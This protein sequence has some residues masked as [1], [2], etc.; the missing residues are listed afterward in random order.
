MADTYETHPDEVI[1]ALLGLIKLYAADGLSQR[2]ILNRVAWTLRE[3]GWGLRGESDCHLV[4]IIT[5]QA[6]QVAV[7][8]GQLAL[9][10]AGEFDA[11]SFV[12]PVEPEIV[13]L[14]EQQPPAPTHAAQAAPA[15]PPTP[16]QFLKT[17]PNADPLPP[18]EQLAALDR[19]LDHVIALFEG[20]MTILD[21]LHGRQDR[22]YRGEMRVMGRKTTVTL[23][24]EDPPQ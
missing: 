24:P 9:L 15:P 2:A 10:N 14:F 5:G 22:P 12:D 20:L 8:D 1:E 13:K 16:L 4:N 11:S 6:Y 17:P 19:K 7:Q 18:A 23:T 3:N 21:A